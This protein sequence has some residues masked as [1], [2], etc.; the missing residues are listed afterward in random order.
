MIRYLH[1][2]ANDAAPGL[3]CDRQESPL[4]NVGQFVKLVVNIVEPLSSQ[5][6]ESACHYELFCTS[7]TR[8]FCKPVNSEGEETQDVAIL[9][10]TR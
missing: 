3:L 4:P 7:F 2:V 10:G 9:G 5:F 8:P 1:L 6:L